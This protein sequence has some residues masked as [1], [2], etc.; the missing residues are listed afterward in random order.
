MAHTLPH[1]RV[2][3][4][5]VNTQPR[6]GGGTTLLLPALR[7]RS[8][9]GG[10]RCMVRGAAGKV[11]MA[12]GKVR[13]VVEVRRAVVGVV[14]M[15]ARR[16]CARVGGVVARVAGQARCHSRRTPRSSHRMRRM[17]RMCSSR[18]VVTPRVASAVSVAV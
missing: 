2:H 16:M 1:F 14:R 8:R 12:V 4:H 10:A 9:T 15:R 3:T 6:T 5:R 13:M 17:R 11:R 18:S 7:S